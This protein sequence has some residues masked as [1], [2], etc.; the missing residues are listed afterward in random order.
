LSTD[1]YPALQVQ[2]TTQIDHFRDESTELVRIDNKN[3]QTKSNK[4][5]QETQITMIT[6]YT[7]ETHNIN[8]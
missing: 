2:L 1:F 7:H 5:T 4:L 6:K 8:E 3:Q